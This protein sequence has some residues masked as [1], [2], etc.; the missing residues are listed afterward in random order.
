MAHSEQ[1]LRWTADFAREWGAKLHVAHVPPAI[2]WGAAEWF[3]HD[4]Q[5]LIRAA[6]RERLGK[7]VADV[8]CD[9]DLHLEGLEPISYVNEV[10]E[11]TDADVLVVGRSIGHGP[12]GGPRGNAYAMIREAHCPVIS[13]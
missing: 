7:L 2:D 12:L 13:V 9:V 1:V 6:S 8:G 3:P 4:T 10:I 5:E 11:Q